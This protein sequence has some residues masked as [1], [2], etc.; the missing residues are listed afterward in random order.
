MKLE[1][2][3]LLGGRF[4]VGHTLGRG[5]IGLVV[6]AT[7]ESSGQDVALKI[8]LPE[9]AESPI[10]RERFSREL[11]VAQSLGDHPGFVRIYS[12]HD[13]GDRCF[14]AMERLPGQDLARYLRAHPRPPAGERRAI[15]AA[16]LE[17]L[18][19]AHAR[20]VVHRDIKPG[21]I[22][23]LGDGVVKLLD[24]GLARVGAYS[25]LTT[26]SMVLGTPDYLAPE[27]V[28][29]RPI[30]ARADL[31]GLGVTWYELATGQLPFVA[32]SVYELLHQKATRDG[33][34]PC[35]D[36][37]FPGEAELIASLLRL[38]PDARP[39]TAPAVL[40]ALA[41][42][43]PR[44]VAPPFACAA[45]GEPS[46]Q[47]DDCLACGASP[48]ARPGGSMV[49]LTRTDRAPAAVLGEL[50]RHGATPAP[51]IDPERAL[52]SP[53]VVLVSDVD[54][55]YAHALQVRLVSAGHT[56]E[57]RSRDGSNF[58]LLHRAETPGLFL[59][60]GIL[61][62]WAAACW[63]GWFAVGQ[64]GLVATL[65]AGPPA[66]WFIHKNAHWFLPA[67]FRLPR[68]QA[69]AMLL[70][71]E[72]RAFRALAPPPSAL[73][74][75]RA[76]IR[77]LRAALTQLDPDSARA[78]VDAARSSLAL[79]ATIAQIDRELEAHARSRRP[80]DDPAAEAHARWLEARE[81]ERA[82]RVQAVLEVIAALDAI[83]TV[84]LD[85]QLSAQRALVTELSHRERAARELAAS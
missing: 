35:G 11:G 14:F 57:V 29:G 49:V 60:G 66:G 46:Q 84:A 23:R 17:T 83:D 24:F 73:G 53:P 26:C 52:A 37:L 32:P 42:P 33:P 18:A 51:G 38:D 56:I 31:Y 77:R 47:L 39:A 40:R 34:V 30:D 41:T 4:R 69:A 25:D 10:T 13:D 74:L 75:G 36:D 45:C 21:N 72:W 20:G 6:A 22:M 2:G 44:P 61:G 19:Y 3:T 78:A 54:A 59:V 9:H 65:A 43:P 63:L 79:L 76:L 67:A 1:P 7:D 5:A 48:A 12:F 8:L 28:S 64:W 70:A 82:R 85:A 55:A 62:A 68:T 80:G 81:D 71:P 50:A 16:I 58:D 27:A 15:V